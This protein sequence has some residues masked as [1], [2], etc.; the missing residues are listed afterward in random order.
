MAKPVFFQTYRIMIT[1]IAPM[2][3]APPKNRFDTENLQVVI[4]DAGIL[5]VKEAPDDS[6]IGMG[7]EYRE[8]KDGAI[9]IVHQYRQMPIEHD[10]KNQAD[11]GAVE[12]GK[13]RKDD[14]ID[15]GYTHTWIGKHVGIVVQADVR[16]TVQKAELYHQLMRMDSIRG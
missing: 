10:R 15:I 3:I 9:Q 8:E 14:C 2:R 7:D 5:L 11:A 13:S 6:D 16:R 4:D 12:V 1:A